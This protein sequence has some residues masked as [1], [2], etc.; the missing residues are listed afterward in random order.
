MSTQEIKTLEDA[1][2]RREEVLRNLR[3]LRKLQHEIQGKQRIEFLRTL[4]WKFP[5][6][7]NNLRWVKPKGKDNKMRLKIK[8]YPPVVE[9]GYRVPDAI[10][11]LHP[12]GLEPVVVHN[13]EEL[14]K[15]DPRR[16]IIYI[17]S[18]VGA[19]KRKQIIEKAMNMGFKV[20][21]G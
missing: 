12:S 7:E 9:I 14:D 18:T 15:L 20:A 17:A 8:G 5:K 19:R 10:R 6:F 16:Y 21:N 2:K 11:G 3:E 1:L 13:A 4:W